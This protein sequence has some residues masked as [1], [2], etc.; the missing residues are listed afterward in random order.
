MLRTVKL[1]TFL[2]N[3]MAKKVK[4]IAQC[5]KNMV[6]IRKI[7]VENMQLNSMWLREKIQ[8]MLW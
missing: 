3:Y 7:I 4:N 5:M 2:D 8:T 6:I 1:D